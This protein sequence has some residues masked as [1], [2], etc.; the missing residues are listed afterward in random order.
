MQ[1]FFQSEI[2][3]SRQGKED[4]I[5]NI[6]GYIQRKT[7]IR[8]P[9]ERLEDALKHAVIRSDA[10]FKCLC[11]KTFRNVSSSHV[12]SFTRYIN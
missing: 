12:I 9:L 5:L 3:K 8:S 10:P 6:S 2:W 11:E 4:E 7:I 1:G